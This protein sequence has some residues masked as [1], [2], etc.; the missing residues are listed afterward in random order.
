MNDQSIIAAQAARE[1][2]LTLGSLDLLSDHEAHSAIV[3]RL[4]WRLDE[5][6]AAI[7]EGGA[8]R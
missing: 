2:A 8:T 1:L 6:L 7:R 3:Q 4:I 5:L